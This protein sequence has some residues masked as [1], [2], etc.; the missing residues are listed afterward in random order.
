[1]YYDGS[2]ANYYKDKE[3]YDAL[4]KHISSLDEN[5]K[6]N[7]WYP[8]LKHMNRMES[9]IVELQEKVEKYQKFFSLLSSLLP[10]QSTIHDIIG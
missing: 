7:E 1:M 2:T 9:D 10:K 6:L 3:K 4:K 8:A 5:Q